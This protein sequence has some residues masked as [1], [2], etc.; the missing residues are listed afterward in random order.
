MKYA[1]IGAAMSAILLVGTP[2]AAMP[3]SSS[4]KASSIPFEPKA[5]KKH[6]HRPMVQPFYKAGQVPFVLLP[7]PKKAKPD[8]KAVPVH[9]DC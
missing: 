9:K 7:I 2:A 8:H 5:P 4:I 6:K 1:I 3:Q